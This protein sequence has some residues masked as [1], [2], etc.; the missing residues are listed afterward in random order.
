MPRDYG[1]AEDRVQLTLI[2]LRRQAKSCPPRG[3]RREFPA[4]SEAMD[5]PCRSSHRPL[6]AQCPAES[7]LHLQRTSPV[8]LLDW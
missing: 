6:L 5:E 8:D 1:L 4:T 7:S 3:L 2:K